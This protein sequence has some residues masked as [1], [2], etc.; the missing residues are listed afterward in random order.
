MRVVTGKYV[1]EIWIRKEAELLA[2]K[3]DWN[4]H[5]CG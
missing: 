2:I 5:H 1:F 3:R 4:D